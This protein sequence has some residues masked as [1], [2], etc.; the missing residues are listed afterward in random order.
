MNANVACE[1]RV[2]YFVAV[3]INN[4]MV[5]QEDTI[6]L[7]PIVKFDRISKNDRW[8]VINNENM[9]YYPHSDVLE[10]RGSAF[11]EKILK[12]MRMHKFM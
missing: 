3:K 5:E 2:I 8:I 10:L 6:K 7:K 9:I 12:A 1:Q 4:F 11:S